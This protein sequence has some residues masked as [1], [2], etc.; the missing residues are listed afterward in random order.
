MYKVNADSDLK[1]VIFVKYQEV[2]I[3]V[4]TKI[5]ENGYFYA[6]MS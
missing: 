3:A 2:F 5:P 4:N 6:E 1:N